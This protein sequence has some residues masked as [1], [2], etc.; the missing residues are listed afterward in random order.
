VLRRIFGVKT[1]EIIGWR[2]LHSEELHN[3]YSSP[4]IIIMSRSRRMG[5]E[6]HL[7]RIREEECK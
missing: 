2:K 6:G 3:L 4:N 1:D 7:A 5:L